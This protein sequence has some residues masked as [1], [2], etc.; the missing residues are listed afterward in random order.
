MLASAAV[1]LDSWRMGYDRLVMFAT[2]RYVSCT[3]SNNQFAGNVSSN[4]KKR[5]SYALDNLITLYINDICYSV[6]ATKPKWDGIV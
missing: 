6:C 4:R 3:I 2:C 5:V 1:I